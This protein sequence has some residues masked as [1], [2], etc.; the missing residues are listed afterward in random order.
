MLKVSRWAIAWWV[1]DYNLDSLSRYN[2][3]RND[4][5]GQVIWDYISRHG[6]AIGEPLMSG[7]LKLKGYRAQ[8]QRVRSSLNRVDPK[9]HSSTLGSS[10]I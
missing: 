9:K 3:M 5:L 8:P 10:S 1:D 6:P 7:Y 4:E 2:N